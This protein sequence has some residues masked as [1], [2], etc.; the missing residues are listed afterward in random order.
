M[1]SVKVEL[2]LETGNLA[3]LE[4][5][6]QELFELCH[7]VNDKTSS[8]ALPRNHRLTSFRLDTL[9]HVVE[10]EREGHHVVVLFAVPIFVVCRFKVLIVL[11]GIRGVIVVVVLGDNMRVFGSGSSLTT[12]NEAA[13]GL[14]CRGR[15]WLVGGIAGVL[16]PTCH[17]RCGWEGFGWPF[18][19]AQ[20]C[21][22]SFGAFKRLESALRVDLRYD[23]H[24]GKG[25]SYIGELWFGVDAIDG[26]GGFELW[27]VSCFRP[28]SV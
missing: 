27:E 28:L 6:G 10:F 17:T 4:I 3:E 14:G 11:H 25:D 8:M 18:H 16:V 23:A 15:A 13:T 20:R 22:G 19:D 21:H 12:A 24:L 9:Q 2:A 1:K 26:W 5:V 7:I